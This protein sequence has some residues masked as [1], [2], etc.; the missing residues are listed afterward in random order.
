M[1]RGSQEHTLDWTYRVGLAVSSFIVLSC[2]DNSPADRVPAD[3]L[4][5]GVTLEGDTLTTADFRDH[6]IL[7][8]FWASWCGSCRLA[9]SD[10]DSLW[11][12]FEAPQDAS[13]VAISFDSNQAAL[14]NYLGDK[15]RPFYITRANAAV[16][17]TFHVNGI[18]TYYVFDRLGY[19]RWRYVG[20]A[21]PD[22]IK[23]ALSRA[24]WG[25]WFPLA[26]DS[27]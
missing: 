9:F 26:T 10:L 6:V 27:D 15:I 16:A 5:L 14:E 17:D 18:P 23:A 7:A 4:P 8:C 25:I 12:N 24:E 19:K 22:T 20:Y 2:H 1:Y 13:L 21:P 11:S 3:P